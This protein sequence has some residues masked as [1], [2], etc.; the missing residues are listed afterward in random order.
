VKPGLTA[1]KMKTKKYKS[2][3]FVLLG[4]HSICCDWK[5]HNSRG[6]RSAGERE[7]LPMGHCGRSVQI[8]AWISTF[9]TRQTLY[10]QYIES[11]TL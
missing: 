10:I 3:C 11:K 7:T 9:C 4:E 2:L 6:Q 8:C 5:Q 1:L